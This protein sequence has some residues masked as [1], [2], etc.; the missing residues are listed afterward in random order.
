M[1]VIGP[2]R[3]GGTEENWSRKE[4]YGGKWP[5]LAVTVHGMGINDGKASP[6]SAQNCSHKKW[7]FGGLGYQSDKNGSSISE[8]S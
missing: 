1:G 7:M 3:S 8:L 4:G 5:F 2:R 6:C